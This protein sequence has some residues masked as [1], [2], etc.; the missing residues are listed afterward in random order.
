MS[1]YY[2]WYISKCKKNNEKI[3]EN[4]IEW[5]KRVEDKVILIYGIKLLD[6][7]DEDYMMYFKKGINS[8]RMADKIFQNNKI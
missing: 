4:F 2:D 3:N 7:P 6:L 5:I 8:E 1:F